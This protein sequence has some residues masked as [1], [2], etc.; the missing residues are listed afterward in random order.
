MDEQSDMADS[1]CF[2]SVDETIGDPYCFESDHVALKGN[3]DYHHLLRTICVL[4]AQR[5]KAL[6]DLELLH[7]A[8]EKVRTGMV[9]RIYIYIKYSSI[10][11]SLSV[12]KFKQNY[13]CCYYIVQQYYGNTFLFNHMT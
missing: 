9:T 3:P 6:K 7:E 10:S 4:E 11:L 12:K 13:T 8:Q 5:S 2:D 1:P